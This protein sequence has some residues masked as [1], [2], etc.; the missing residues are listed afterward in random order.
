MRKGVF[1]KFAGVVGF[2]KEQIE[3][4]RVD[5]LALVGLS[6]L[7]AFVVIAFL[8]PVVAPYDPWERFYHKDGTLMRIDPPSSEHILGTTLF[9]RDILSQLIYGTSNSLMIALISAALVTLIGTNIGLISGYFSGKIDNLLMRATDVAYCLPL[10]ATAI[11]FIML[12]GRSSLNV[13][14]AIVALAWRS[15]ARVI[16]SQVLTIKELEY[17]KAARIS[18]AGHF[19][20]LYGHIAPN[21]LSM[22]LLYSAFAVSWSVIMESTISFLGMG[23]PQALSWGRMLYEA[24]FANAMREAWWWFVAPGICI[25]LLA[26]AAFLIGQCYEVIA[27]PKLREA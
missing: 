22:S 1:R 5:R 11:V 18:G 4:L 12:L 2:F 15:T 20:I 6:I 24:F 19:R 10:E 7:L 3:I 25:M 8:A 16:R 21:I 13:I 26:M 17:V 27:N 9:G 14:L 23:D